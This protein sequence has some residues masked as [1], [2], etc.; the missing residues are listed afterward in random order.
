MV[1][2]KDGLEVGWLVGATVLQSASIIAGW[3]QDGFAPPLRKQATSVAKSVS[4]HTSLVVSNVGSTTF[5]KSVLQGDD[6]VHAAISAEQNVVGSSH[7]FVDGCC[8]GENEG[9]G[10][11][12]EVGAG[13]LQ[14]GEI[15]VGCAQDGL[16]PPIRKQATSAA[17]S[18][19]AHTSF[20]VSNVGSTTLFNSAL[21]EDD[22]EHALISA[23]Q[24]VVG[25]SHVL[26]PG[27]TFTTPNISKPIQ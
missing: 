9:A 6:P 10:V 20:A 16:V 12:W 3:A 15:I 23:A 13:L 2:E 4:A 7:G 19:S 5:S 14:S 8:D 27:A 24:K 11:G 1:G 21:H 18:V 26:L 17:K 25:S 22:P